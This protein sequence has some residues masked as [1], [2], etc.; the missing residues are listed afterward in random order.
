MRLTKKLRSIATEAIDLRDRVIW[1]EGH[2]K[3]GRKWYPREMGECCKGI[4]D[5]SHAYPY[6][7]LSHCRTVRHV[8]TVNEVDPSRLAWAI[9]RIDK[10]E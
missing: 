7:L 2:T 5:P 9:K 3:R 1:P 10:G 8:A 6:S 4:R